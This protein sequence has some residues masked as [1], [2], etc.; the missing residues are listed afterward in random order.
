MTSRHYTGSATPDATKRY[1]SDLND[2]EFALIAPHVA[3]K[4]G[5]GKKRTIDIREVLN[6]I[7]YR[8]RTGCQ[9]RMLPRDFPAWYHVWYY[10]RTWRDDGTWEHINTLL[11]RDVRTKA[12][13]DPGPSVGIIDSQS[14]ETTEMG[15][16]KGFNPA[17][18]VKGRKRH[19][20]TDTLGLILF[21][22]VC[23]ASIA[24]SDGAEYIF[25]ETEGQFPRLGT[26][27]VDQGY[28]SRLVEFTKH[29][30]GIIR[31][32]RSLP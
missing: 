32:T 12:G 23:A 22:V 28:K 30:F 13:R 8:T 7:F 16:E 29:W 17:K 9:W 5:S 27:L 25:H 26:V 3:Q 15:G 4:S 20:M 21:V 6:A 19:L 24:D 31:D 10:Y 18:Q 11:R 1:A 2:R 14:V